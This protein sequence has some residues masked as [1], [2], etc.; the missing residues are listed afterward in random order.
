MS[1]AETVNKRV[2]FLSVI[3][4][5]MSRIPYCELFIFVYTGVPVMLYFVLLLL[6]C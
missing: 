2:Y 5:K 3:Y 1:V 4:F 6:L